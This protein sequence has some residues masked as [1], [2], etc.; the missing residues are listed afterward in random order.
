MAKEEV[1]A[2]HDRLI[3][4]FGGSPGIRDH[5]LLE[6][7]LMAPQS[8]FWYES[9][10]LV[11]CAATYAYHIAKNHAFVDGN[12]RTGEAVMLSCVYANGGGIAATE[13]ELEDL[14]LGIASN[15][16]SRDETERILRNW[17]VVF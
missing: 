6:S 14:F 4:E 8:R 5:G 17:I 11:I 1:C 15:T 10:D 13:K 2:L 12:K 16:I 9:A 7:A 3:A